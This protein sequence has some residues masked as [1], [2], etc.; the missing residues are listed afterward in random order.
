MRIHNT[1]SKKVEE[2]EPISPGFVSVYSCG[3]TVYNHAHIG[4]LSA[5]IYADT[6]N[7]ALKASGLKV[8]HVMNLTDVDDKTI[9]ASSEQYPD[10]DPME[11][12]IKL[13]TLYGD[14][15]AADMISVGNDVNAY[16]FVKA[17]NS[18]SAMKDLIKTL[19]DTNFA[20]ISDDGVYFS[21]EAYRKSGKKYGQLSEISASSTSNARIDN[22]EY[23]KE[24]IHDFALWKKQKDNEPA[25]PFELNEHDLTGRPGW[26]LE[27]S[28]MSRS[29][30][31]QPFDIHSGGID[32]IFPHHENEIAQSTAVEDNQTYAK[33]F[34]HSEHLLVDGKK[35][36][37]SLNNFYTLSDIKDKGY[38][39][40]AFRLLVLQ[41]HYRGQAHFSFENL[42]AAE[43]RLYDLRAMAA[44]RW[45][46]R[47]VTHDASTFALE[48]VI[49]ALK[50]AVEDDLNT[51]QALAF[52]SNVATQLQT[53]HIEED[54]LDHMDRMLEGIDAIL[55]L[56]L[57][58]VKDISTQQKDL[59]KKREEARISKDWAEADKLR[60]E[61]EKQK[62]AVRDATHGPIWYWVK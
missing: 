54:M 20:Y 13:T 5:F 6:L 26:H 56:D 14:A 16:R 19:V 29:V 47:N 53:V 41:S 40:L 33:Y 35:M 34:V 59:I 48:D 2:L 57:S 1:L 30:L 46:P 22:D 23:D 25:W 51:P 38:D 43:N 44:L 32:L 27:C 4:N 8:K 42:E 37:K 10:L 45:Q 9:K 50:A 24:S 28:V 60:N 18:I 31:G 52:L 62:I 21:I 11:A 3:P 15:F 7:R 39:P 12:L 49:V 58:K 17:T 61:L 55:G 36:A